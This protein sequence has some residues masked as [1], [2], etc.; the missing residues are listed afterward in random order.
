MMNV[1]KTEFKM[2]YKMEHGTLY[3]YDKNEI[4][5]NFIDNKF[6]IM[7]DYNNGNIVRL[8]MGI[9][10]DVKKS[11]DKYVKTYNDNKTPMELRPDLRIAT[12][13]VTENDVEDLN[14][15]LDI[16]GYLNIWLK[17]KLLNC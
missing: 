5:T 2:Q 17:K 10:K 8:K 1:Q 16:T 11:F 9:P 3:L 13:V 14:K 15:I 4:I 6:S 12:F 7:Y